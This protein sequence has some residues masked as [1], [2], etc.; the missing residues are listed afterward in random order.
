M[1]Y[2]LARHIGYGVLPSEKEPCNLFAVVGLWTY[3]GKAS[4]P[5][6]VGWYGTWEKAHEVKKYLENAMETEN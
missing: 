6:V 3:R 4:R 5:P 2:Q 1:P